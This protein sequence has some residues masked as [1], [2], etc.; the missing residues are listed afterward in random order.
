MA[1]PSR[2][3]EHRVGVNVANDPVTTIRPTGTTIRFDRISRVSSCNA[4][5]VDE[6]RLL[7]VSR[8]GAVVTDISAVL[9]TIVHAARYATPRYRRAEFLGGIPRQ[10]S[11][12]RVRS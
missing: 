6:V 10:D 4:K 1:S 8:G 2:A 12:L 7:L 9:L 3:G 11:P 5:L